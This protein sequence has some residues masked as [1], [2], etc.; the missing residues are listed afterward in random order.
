MFFEVD[1]SAYV[2]LTAVP[3]DQEY[4]LKLVQITEQA[5]DKNG[6][7]FVQFLFEIVDHPNTK[8]VSHF[9]P[10]PHPQR[11]ETDQNRALGAWA[12]LEEGLG[13]TMNGVSAEEL[14]GTRCF[15]LLD[16][17]ENDQYGAQNNIKRFVGPA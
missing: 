7:P 3:G 11:S 8:I 4:E 16:Y 15:A 9:M 12:K 17:K 13:V 1:T 14:I 2:P 10:M 6:L 5:T